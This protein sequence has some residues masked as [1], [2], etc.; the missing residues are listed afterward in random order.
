MI[1]LSINGLAD[2][3]SIVGN[4]SRETESRLTLYAER[5]YEW[6]QRINLLSP[7]DMKALWP[8]HI[9]DCAQLLNIAPPGAT[10]LDIGSGAGLPGM[11][12]A[13]LLQEFG[14]GH[15]HLVESNRKKAAFL[16]QIQAET[17]APVTVHS[18]RVQELP[19]KMPQIHVVTA[20]AVA[21]LPGLLEMA[22]PW[23]TSGARSFF[24][25][26]RDYQAELE[27]CRDAWSFALVEHQSRT[28]HEAVI[29]EISELGRRE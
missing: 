23:L 27:Q 18:K 6:N 11:V 14:G 9:V 25:K 19:E 29:L 16:L 5:L 13:L 10:W 21:A 8:R 2:V 4:V 28:D 15:V 1:G 26:G 3:R 22:E 7:T 20:R 12:V 24:Q 17:G